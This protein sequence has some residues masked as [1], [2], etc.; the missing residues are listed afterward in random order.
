MALVCK[1]CNRVSR[2]TPGWA[3]GSW[4]GNFQ[5]P[6]SINLVSTELVEG[7]Q[8]QHGL[9]GKWACGLNACLWAKCFV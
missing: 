5:P 7:G 1:S 9:Q 2:P 6:G 3:V 4:K 8:L